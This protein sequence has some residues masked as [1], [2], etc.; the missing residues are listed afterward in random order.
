MA[1]SFDSYMLLSSLCVLIFSFSSSFLRYIP[2]LFYCLWTFLALCTS[3]DFKTDAGSVIFVSH[4]FYHFFNSMETWCFTFILQVDYEYNTSSGKME[5]LHGREHFTSNLSILIQWSPYSTEAELLKQVRS[6]HLPFVAL[7][8]LGI[9]TFIGPLT[10]LIFSSCR[11]TKIGLQKAYN[12]AS[13]QSFPSPLKNLE[14]LSFQRFHRFYFTA[15]I[16][17]TLPF[18]LILWPHNR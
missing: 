17:K 12:L 9:L 2:K 11:R 3:F 4:W 15:Y 5:I 8:Y 1:W 6:F 7:T 18:P 16:C 13:S 14:F 10:T